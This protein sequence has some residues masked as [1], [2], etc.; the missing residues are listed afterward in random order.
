MTTP[1]YIT[2]DSPQWKKLK[3]RY[4]EALNSLRLV[5]LHEQH[6]NKQGSPP[7]LENNQSLNETLNKVEKFRQKLFTFCSESVSKNNLIITQE[8]LTISIKKTIKRLQEE[9]EALSLSK[10]QYAAYLSIISETT[11]LV[12]LSSN[13]LNE[14]QQGNKD[15]YFSD[16]PDPYEE[17][18]YYL[19]TPKLVDHIIHSQFLKFTLD[20]LIDKDQKKPQP[21]SERPRRI[22]LKL[23]EKKHISDFVATKV[24]IDTHDIISQSLRQII[25]NNINKIIHHN[26]K[27]KA[28]CWFSSSRNHYISRLKKLTLFKQYILDF[29]HLT[30]MAVSIQAN[31]IMNH[32]QHTNFLFRF[33]SCKTK[34]AKNIK[35]ICHT[36]DDNCMRTRERERI[37]NNTVG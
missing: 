7:T 29:Q 4:N 17:M 3:N 26:K 14:I 35:E 9:C 5:K 15:V 20:L 16:K 34:T 22:P 23:H 11:D 18:I 1:P 30:Y 21:K 19:P 6:P 33:F 10:A 2:V 12:I 27:Q 31:D 28:K 36:L 32:C 37:F 13:R 24:S 8:Q 25:T